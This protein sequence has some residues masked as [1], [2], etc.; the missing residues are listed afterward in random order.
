MSYRSSYF[1][2]IVSFILLFITQCSS[3]PIEGEIMID[4]P[5]NN[6]SVIQK[7][8]VKGTVSDPQLIVYVLV[9]P[10]MTNQWWV[11][12]IPAVD[13]EGRWQTLCYFGTKTEG[14]GEQFEVIAV[15][16][17]SARMFRTGETMEIIPKSLLRS[18]IITVRREN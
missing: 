14:I 13:S 3:K 1:L 6:V 7:Q 2:A 4:D 12:N 16:G 11:Q 15:A 10:I 9:H 17:R 8:I 18:Q 5:Q